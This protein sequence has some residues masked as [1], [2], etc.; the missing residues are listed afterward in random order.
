[1]NRRYPH[2]TAISNAPRKVSL[3]RRY[4]KQCMMHIIVSLT[5]FVVVVIVIIVVV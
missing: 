2:P 5:I 4:A 1:M 3:V